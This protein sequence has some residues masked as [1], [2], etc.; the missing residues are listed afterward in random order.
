M[1]EISIIIWIRLAPDASMMLSRPFSL[2]SE[3]PPRLLLFRDIITERL[4]CLLLILLFS[5]HYCVCLSLFI[6]LITLH[7]ILSIII[8]MMMSF[9][10]YAIEYDAFQ[11]AM[12]YLRRYY[13]AP[14]VYA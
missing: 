1:E 8:F 9:S 11:V 13:F 7:S 2:I 3:M 4:R 14:T 6:M 5:P 12:P 10:Y